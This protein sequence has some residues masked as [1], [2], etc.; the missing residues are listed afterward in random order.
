MVDN[1]PING[2]WKRV[3]ISTDS[4]SG[5]QAAA[6]ADSAAAV[7][8]R[9]AAHRPTPVLQLLEDAAPSVGAA[10]LRLIR[11]LRAGYPAS[12][13]ARP[14]ELTARAG[15]PPHTLDAL[16]AAAG[17]RDFAEAQHQA[18]AAIDR[19]LRTPDARYSAR[20]A[21]RG[22]AKPASLLDRIAEQ[23]CANVTS[24]LRTLAATGS[25]HDAAEA[26]VR[27][28]RRYLVADRKSYAYAHL[29]GTDLQS[30]LR[31]VVVIDGLVNRPLDVLPDVRAGDVAICFSLRRYATSS[32][33]T[34]RFM[35]AAG[36]AIIG[37]TDDSSSELAALASIVLVVETT[38][39]SF[40]DS[41]TAVASTVH[42]LATLAAAQTRG[43]RARL[44]QRD[45]LARRLGVYEE[46]EASPGAQLAS[47][48]QPRRAGL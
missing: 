38:S 37:I 9:A 11:T 3:E 13:L 42:A 48:P 47:R 29:L 10:G 12:M 40:V 7:A 27:A 1:R 33:A 4:R 28:R 36:A 22:H 2:N 26:L 30:F 44:A 25:L 46:T 8:S 43:A 31:D 39:Q 16:A 32:L 5:F 15:V 45:E 41:P 23:D 21:G 19:D 6:A 20:L 17:F 14:G 34:A 18:R 24:T 35:H